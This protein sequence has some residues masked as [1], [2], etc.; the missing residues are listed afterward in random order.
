MVYLKGKIT[1]KQ[2]GFSMNKHFKRFL[3]ST[4]VII[5]LCLTMQPI[6][7]Q[8]KA[9]SA[10]GF[11]IDAQAYLRKC[12][13]ENIQAA[14]L[15]KS[16]GSTHTHQYI[17]TKALAILRNDQGSSILNNSTNASELK[18]YTDW[19]DKVGNESDSATYSGHFYNPYTEKSWTGSKTKNA[20]TRAMGYFNDAIEA[21][22]AGNMSDAIIN[23]GKG[24][25]Y[26]SDMNEPHHAS[27]LTALNSNH[28]EFE[29]YV[30]ENRT[31]FYIAGSTLDDYLYTETQTRAMSDILKDGAFYA[32]DLK[33]MAQ[34]EDTYYEAANLCVQH[35]IQN[36]AQYLYAFGVEAGI[37]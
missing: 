25:H 21:A 36:V 22:K 23:I 14:P 30:D 24:T 12:A 28:T 29:K 5:M 10:Q 32:Y 19:P 26:V 9:N 8:A 4:L 1:K 33:Y 2:G 16:G 34:E 7:T 17:V 31:K 18:T 27:N 11:T 13:P 37:Y 3:A 15:F 20:L 35:A 6:T